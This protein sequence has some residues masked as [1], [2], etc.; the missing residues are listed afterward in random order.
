MRGPF[1]GGVAAQP[2]Q[3][4]A[5][6]WMLLAAVAPLPALE[7]RVADPGAA[8]EELLRRAEGDGFVTWSHPVPN[9]GFLKGKEAWVRL[10]LAGK[11]DAETPVVVEL[12]IARLLR[13]DWFIAAGGRIVETAKSGVADLDPAELADQRLP[14]VAFAI[15]RGESRTVLL[16]VASD[17]AVWLPLRVGSP[18]EHAAWSRSRVATDFALLGACL[19][20]TALSLTLGLITRN[21]VYLLAGLMPLAHVAYQAIFLGYHQSHFPWLPR[22]VSK[23]GMLLFATVLGVGLFAFTRRVLNPPGKPPGK[24]TTA[25]L[26]ASLAAVAAVLFL[27]YPLGSQAANLLLVVGGALCAAASAAAT[28]S[29]PRL[30]ALLLMAGWCLPLGSGML[31]LLQLGGHSPAWFSPSAL[32][33]LILP[34]TFVLFMLAAVRSQRRLRETELRLEGT[35]R[36]RESAQLEALRHQLNPHLAF[37]TLAS[38]E[39]L[40]RE[41]PERIPALVNR[42]ASFLRHRM[43]PSGRTFQT[44][45]E[46]LEAAKAYLDIEATH[47]EE[48]LKVELG[49]D[50]ATLSLLVPEFTLQPLVENA[51]KHGLAESDRVAIRIETSAKGGRLRLRVANT[52]RIRQRRP[53]LRGEGIGLDNLRQRLAL[54]LGDRA[55]AG[56]READGWVVAEVDLPALRDIP[57]P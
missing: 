10:E 16:R 48:R 14:S 45:G 18:R 38:I 47:L 2:G 19:G 40:S 57:S 52:G 17:T 24:A 54:H 26:G 37:N 50:E 42:L 25:A 4:L 12:G 15:P 55:G 31:L 20:I 6:A 5:T 34:G 32:I 8:P 44:Q 35:R 29:T 49:V 56:L 28:R 7:V 30:E 27:P 3:W 41:A 21:S 11:P 46:E 1:N 23:E 39:T 53:R 22:W 36:Q 33:R 13:A 51:V 43:R 9:L